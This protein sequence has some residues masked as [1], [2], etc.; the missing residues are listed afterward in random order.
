MASVEEYKQKKIAIMQPYFLPYIGYWQLINAVDE[1][2]VYDNIKYTKKGW[3]NRNRFLLN[4][5][6][7]L[8]SIP[9]K[10]DS[11]FLDVRERFIADSFDREKL[12]NQLKA[13]YNKAPQFKNAIPVFEEI[14]NNREENVFLYILN[15]IKIICDHLGIRTKITISSSIDINHKNLKS[16]DK[17]LAICKKLKADKYINAIGGTELYEKSTFKENGLDLCFL[18]SKEINYNQL[19]GGFVPWLSILD[20]AMFNSKEKVQEMLN[21][22]DIL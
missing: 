11:D 10:S 1:F 16:Q 12:L 4:G 13:A 22:Y 9:L 15:S 18:K 3:I 5:K 7:E 8:F 20:V 21:A 6:D 14:I 19:N 17:V 2:V